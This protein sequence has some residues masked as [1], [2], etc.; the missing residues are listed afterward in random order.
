M[1]GYH[2]SYNITRY[3][4]LAF[5][6]HSTQKINKFPI[7]GHRGILTCPRFFKIRKNIIQELL[8]KKVLELRF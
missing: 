5:A 4:G 8:G 7:P 6:S 1:I 3:T 2:F